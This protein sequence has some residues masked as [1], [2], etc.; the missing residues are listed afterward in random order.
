MTPPDW[1]RQRVAKTTTGYNW[2]GRIRKSQVDLRAIAARLLRLEHARAVKIVRKY[3]KRA[4]RT[5][6]AAN[7]KEPPEFT[8]RQVHVLIE[9]VCYE[10]ETALQRGRTQKGTR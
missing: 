5:W 1:A 9:Q 6:R 2:N 3:T 10:I 7:P 8:H 4:E